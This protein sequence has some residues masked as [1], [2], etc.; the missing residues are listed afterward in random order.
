MKTLEEISVY[1]FIEKV[2]KMYNFTVSI[3]K[4]YQ[5]SAYSFWAQRF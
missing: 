1:K 4:S 3:S 2:S 5:L